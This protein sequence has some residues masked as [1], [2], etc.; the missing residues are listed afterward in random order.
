MLGT[1][2]GVQSE[3]GVAGRNVGKALKTGSTQDRP[4]SSNRPKPCPANNPMSPDLGE[5]TAHRTQALAPVAV[6]P[7]R[8]PVSHRSNPRIA[9]AARYAAAGH[10]RPRMAG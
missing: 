5:Q 8:W 7:T 3:A 9:S 4:A 6:V 10:A 1:A 2:P